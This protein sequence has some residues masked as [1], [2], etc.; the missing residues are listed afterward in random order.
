LAADQAGFSR[1]STDN[2]EFLL[3]YEAATTKAE[4]QTKY[5]CLKVFQ[6]TQNKENKKITRKIKNFESYI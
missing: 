3:L 2:T 6:N 5:C 4:F 1:I